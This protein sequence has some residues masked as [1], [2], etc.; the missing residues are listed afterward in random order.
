MS[1]DDGGRKEGTG[2]LAVLL[3][4]SRKAATDI[5]CDES[6]ATLSPRGRGRAGGGSRVNSEGGG[7]ACGGGESPRKWRKD[8][9]SNDSGGAATGD[10]GLDL[11]RSRAQDSSPFLFLV[12]FLG[13]SWSI[14]GEEV[15]S[16]DVRELTGRDLVDEPCTSLCNANMAD[17]IGGRNRPGISVSAL[18]TDGLDILGGRLGDVDWGGAT[19]ESETF[20]RKGSFI[21]LEDGADSSLPWL[22]EWVVCEWVVCDTDSQRDSPSSSETALAL[23]RPVDEEVPM[24]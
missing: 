2:E 12:V 5:R 14:F 20:R 23:D 18:D 6:E 22:C 9:R 11:V 17:L 15:V 1:V 4:A 19:G 10:E 21:R 8:L 3:R 24:P 7:S 16:G 13:G